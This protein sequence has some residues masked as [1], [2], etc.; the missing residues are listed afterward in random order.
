M[1]ANYTLWHFE[2]A[3]NSQAVIN[4]E[5]KSAFPQNAATLASKVQNAASSSYQATVLPTQTG[6]F[7]QRLEMSVFFETKIKKPGEDF[8]TYWQNLFDHHANLMNLEY[9]GFTKTRGSH[10]HDFSEAEIQRVI[11]ASQRYSTSREKRSITSSFPAGARGDA[12]K[13]RMLSIVH[14]LENIARVSNSAF[15]AILMVASGLLAAS[16]AVPIVEN[17]SFLVGLAIGLVESGYTTVAAVAGVV[18]PWAII[19]G[20]SAAFVALLLKGAVN[21]LFIINETNDRILLHGDFIIS[22]ERLQVAPE[23]EAATDTYVSMGIFIYT[24]SSVAGTPVGLFG[25]NFG[26]SLSLEKAKQYFSI[27][28]DSPN[29]ARNSI[30]AHPW[31]DSHSAAIAAKRTSDSLSSPIN[32]NE[33]TKMHFVAFIAFLATAVA[34]GPQIKRLPSLDK[35]TIAEAND[36]CGDNMIIQC[37]ESLDYG[38]TGIAIGNDP[39]LLDDLGTGH[40]CSELDMDAI[41]VVNQLLNNECQANAACC[42][43]SDSTADGGVINADLPCFALSSLL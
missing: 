23:I 4:S 35:M 31:N 8:K 42:Q 24:K 16:K 3:V 38:Q 34:A 9:K 40:Q 10:H 6:A 21:F 14:S 20:I 43:I 27:G 25:S 15:Q 39:E 19:L 37:C 30:T 11:Q 5:N 41:G 2:S 12:L 18:A 36:A 22:G 29:V 1:S 28:M 26:I 17:V 32:L 33:A 13:D 7:R